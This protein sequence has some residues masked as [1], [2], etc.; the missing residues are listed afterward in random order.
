MSASAM[1]GGHNNN[2]TMT[3]YTSIIL[4]IDYHLTADR[5]SAM[6]DLG[7]GISAHLHTA[8]EIH[9]FVDVLVHLTNG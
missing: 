2:H 8:R 3:A 7:C 6:A 1:Q 4:K 9:S 5:N